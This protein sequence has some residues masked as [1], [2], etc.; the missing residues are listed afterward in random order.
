LCVAD[1]EYI[2]HRG[3]YRFDIQL[4][5]VLLPVA[6]F[7]L[8]YIRRKD[9]YDLHHSILGNSICTMLFVFDLYFFVSS[10][11]VMLYVKY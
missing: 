11:F 6:V 7:L 1:N 10:M 4:Y 9:V 8:V 3:L 2:I 5:A